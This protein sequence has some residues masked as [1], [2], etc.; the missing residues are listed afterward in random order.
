MNDTVPGRA[1][2]DTAPG[3]IPFVR[4]SIV[5]SPGV[6]PESQRYIGDGEE[7]KKPG[8]SRGTEPEMKRRIKASLQSGGPTAV[9]GFFSPIP[10]LFPPRALPP[11]A[12]EDS[13]RPVPLLTPSLR[14]PCRRLQLRL[15]GPKAGLLHCPE[16]TVLVPEVA[17]LQP[18]GHK[19]RPFLATPKLLF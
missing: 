1:Q 14:V 2:A 4:L 17:T 7:E 13:C 6:T 12:P 8:V 16:D 5:R 11:S 18:S 3:P 9:C 15:A 10:V 19:P